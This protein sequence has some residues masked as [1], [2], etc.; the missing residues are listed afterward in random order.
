MDLAKLLKKRDK[1]PGPAPK[2]WLL[3]TKLPVSSGSLYR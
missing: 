2:E 3:A 1:P